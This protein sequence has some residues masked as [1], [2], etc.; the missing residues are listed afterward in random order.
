M[1]NEIVSICCDECGEYVPADNWDE[2][3]DY[4]VAVQLQKSINQSS[5]ARTLLSPQAIKRQSKSVNKGSPMVSKRAKLHTLDK[6]L[7]KNK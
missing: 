5:S 2:H 1:D 4:H 7:A 3:K 6:Y